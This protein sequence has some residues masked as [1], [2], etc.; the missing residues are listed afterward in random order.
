MRLGRLIRQESVR[1]FVVRLIAAIGLPLA[2][3]AA[4]LV[5]TFIR[6][7]MSPMGL[8]AEYF[9]KP[10][11]TEPIASRTYRKV[12]VYHSEGSPA[13]GVP[14]E[15]YYA[16]W[17]GFVL[18]P[19]T[20]VYTFRSLSDDG[21]RIFIDGLLL[22]DNWK[23]RGWKRSRKGGEV[24]LA[25]GSH[26]IRI[27]HRN[28]GGPSGLALYWRGGEIPPDTVLAVPYIVKNLFDGAVART[29]RESIR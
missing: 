26:P 16:V 5:I 27:E 8:Q 25:A 18:V 2:L 19:S 9:A 15:N 13:Y 12:F 23:N 17:K 11:D 7:Q 20:A 4:V 3:I 29:V 1:G 6:R 28:R 10:G 24:E 21:I 22:I 14:R